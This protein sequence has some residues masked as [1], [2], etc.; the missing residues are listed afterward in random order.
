VHSP[1]AASAF[2]LPPHKA[3]P[4]FMA[5]A[6]E[7]APHRHAVLSSSPLYPIKGSPRAPLLLAPLLLPSSHAQRRRPKGPAGAPPLAA[8]PLLRR[9]SIPSEPP[10]KTPL[11]SSSFLC[12]PHRDWWPG[13]PVGRRR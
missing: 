10:G 7:P 11:A 9:F 8:D 13:G 3:P 2:P 4:P 1:R 6:G 5:A 12:F